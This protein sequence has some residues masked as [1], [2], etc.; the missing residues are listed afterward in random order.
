MF[1]RIVVY[2]V[3]VPLLNV[4]VDEKEAIKRK[5]G[6]EEGRFYMLGT[7]TNGDQYMS[8]G[9]CTGSCVST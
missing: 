9:E 8:V 7:V 6:Y 1:L 3:V 5:G 4:V 2:L